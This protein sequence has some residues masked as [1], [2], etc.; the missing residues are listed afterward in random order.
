MVR[1]KH[2]YFNDLA[3]QNNV[4]QLK[5]AGCTDVYLAPALQGMYF[6][7]TSLDHFRGL[8]ARRLRIIL[9]ARAKAER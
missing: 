8:V 1:S 3:V 4:R 5:K 7:A 2:E 6:Q 9:E